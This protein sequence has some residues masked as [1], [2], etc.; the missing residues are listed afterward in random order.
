M[1]LAE[2]TVA[3]MAKNEQVGTSHHPRD[4]SGMRWE[5]ELRVWSYA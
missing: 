5:E 1:A 2:K 4:L 3:N